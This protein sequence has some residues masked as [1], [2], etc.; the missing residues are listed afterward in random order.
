MTS[1]RDHACTPEEAVSKIQSGHRVF[2]HGAACTPTPFL[3]ALSART[4][5]SNVRV[6]H[7]H[8]TGQVGR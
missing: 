8:L 5:V 4:D 6:Y 7:L 3:D 2:V 1:Y